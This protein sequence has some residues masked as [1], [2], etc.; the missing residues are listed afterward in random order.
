VVP[1]LLTKSFFE[2]PKE[3][4]STSTRI[5]NHRGI[6]SSQ[7]L[8]NA[9]GGHYTQAVRN[10]LTKYNVAAVAWSVRPS[11]NKPGLTNTCS[12]D[13]N[14][15]VLYFFYKN[16]I[17]QHTLPGIQHPLSKLQQIF[18]LLDH[19]NGDDACHLLIHET[20]KDN[21]DNTRLKQLTQPGTVNVWGGVADPLPVLLYDSF[22]CIKD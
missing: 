2:G 10:M 8:L 20:F 1:T 18:D 14:L 16:N 3:S 13:S 5:S 9:Y 6:C 22:L 21:Q 17:L 15:F 4:V 12:Y 19:D 11:H 7:S